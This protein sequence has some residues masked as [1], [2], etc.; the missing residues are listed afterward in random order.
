VGKHHSLTDVSNRRISRT[1]LRNM[2]LLMAALT[3][4]SSP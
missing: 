2:A 4:S 1:D 3:V